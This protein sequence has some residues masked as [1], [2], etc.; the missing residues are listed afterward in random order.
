M[1]TTLR[2]NFV[3]D[4]STRFPLDVPTSFVDA[5]HS[6]SVVLAAEASESSAREAQNVDIVVLSGTVNVFTQE[7]LVN[8]LSMSAPAAST[9]VVSVTSAF[10]SMFDNFVSSAVVYEAVVASRTH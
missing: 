7:R 3:H 6:Q 4:N 1:Y 5:D 9:F 2:G 10:A 8:S